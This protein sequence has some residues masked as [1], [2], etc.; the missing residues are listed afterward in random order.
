[1]SRR[2]ASAFSCPLTVDNLQL[3]RERAEPVDYSAAIP[4]PDLDAIPFI[5]Q[6]A[7]ITMTF[8]PVKWAILNAMAEHCQDKPSWPDYRALVALGWADKKAN[9]NWHHLVGRGNYVAMLLE[10]K[11]CAEYGIHLMKEGAGDS[12]HVRVSCCCGWRA[13]VAKGNHTGRDGR[14]AFNN[15]VA[16]AQG[17]ARI[18]GSLRPFVEAPSV[19]GGE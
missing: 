17:M 9:E 18:V 7:I 11:L 15:H 16:T 12:Y 10:R 1:M 13:S 19:A 3:L 2:N 14:S 5:Q 4:D 8:G 6:V